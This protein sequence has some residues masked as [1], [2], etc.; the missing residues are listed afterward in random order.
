MTT[1]QYGKC[2]VDEGDDYCAGCLNDLREHQALAERVKQ[3]SPPL[4]ET[5]E[6]QQQLKEALAEFS[7]LL[8]KEAIS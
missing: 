5:D 3:L 1:C 2:N 7:K 6:G 8:D 4:L